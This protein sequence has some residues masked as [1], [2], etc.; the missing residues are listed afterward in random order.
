MKIVVADAHHLVRE[1]T[2][3]LLKSMMPNALVEGAGTGADVMAL[4]AADKPD[5]LVTE[6]LLPD[7][8]G[9][10][11]C[12][13][14]LL[15]WRKAGI[16]F[17][18]AAEDHCMV[19]HALDVGALGFVSR[20]C[21]PSEFAAAINAAAAGK[22]YLEHGLATQLAVGRLGTAANR[23]AGMTQREMEILI[24]VARGDSND[25]IARQLSISGKTVANH[26]SSLKGKL[27]ISSPLELLHF[28]VDTGLVRYGLSGSGYPVAGNTCHQSNGQPSQPSM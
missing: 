16:V 5:V 18:G 6:L 21:Q 14:I 3:C 20:N 1:G 7:F 22:L 25:S 2:V 27:E 9:L 24:L 4:Y 8:S 10:E 12:R 11:L 28:A 23:L 15:K 19:R 17:L 26:L 13:R